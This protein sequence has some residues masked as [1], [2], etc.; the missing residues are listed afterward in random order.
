[1]LVERQLGKSG[2]KPSFGAQSSNKCRLEVRTLCDK[3][4]LDVTKSK[5]SVDRLRVDL[6]EAVRMCV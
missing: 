6:V 4:W 2:Y 5:E 1:M 3:E